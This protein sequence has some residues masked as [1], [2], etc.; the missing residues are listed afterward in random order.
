MVIPRDIRWLV[1][2]ALMALHLQYAVAQSFPTK[3]IRIVT[4]GAGGGSDFM[5]RVVA[6]GMASNMGQPV[7]IDNRSSGVIP[8][9]IVSKAAPDGYT[10]LAAGSTFWF[11]PLLGKV[12][13]DPIKDFAPISLTTSAPHILVVTPSLPVTSVKEL[14]ALAKAKPGELNYA[15]TAVGSAGH[16]AGELFKSLAR[17][18]M[19]HI[20]YKGSVAAINDLLSGQ[21]QVMFAPVASATLVKAGKLKGLAV[22]SAQ[23]SAVVPGLP[24]VDAS[25]PG[26]ESGAPQGIFAPARTPAVIIDRLNQEIV[27]V[28]NKAD[29]RERF[30]TTGVDTIAS[31]P[32]Q[33]KRLI[34]A[35]IDRMGQII[36]DAGIRAD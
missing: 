4:T 5:A 36:K 18:D 10:L 14:I 33:F 23:P 19:L 24:T 17:I 25:L 2:V 12:P 31:S 28:L 20:P 32:D 8:G 34:K 21:V 16:L 9:E 6:Q 22:D 30:L 7:I 3:P 11:G 1:P 29:V 35:E 26:F 13:Y 15:S 27:R